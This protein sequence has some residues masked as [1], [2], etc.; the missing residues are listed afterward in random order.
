MN[1]YIFL[2]TLHILSATV[3]LGTGSG[4]AFFKWTV[5]RSSNIA[6]IRVVAEKVVAADWY[7]TT[8][9]IVVQLGTGLLLARMLGLPITHGWLL[10]SLLLFALAGMCWI[11]VVV[12]QLR[13]RALARQADAGAGALNSLYWKYARWWFW[14]GVPAFSGVVVILWLMLQKPD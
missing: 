6:A 13:M 1:A 12:L 2:K 5:D 11:P 3:L 9:A 4:I 8:P 7:F 14:L 10:Y